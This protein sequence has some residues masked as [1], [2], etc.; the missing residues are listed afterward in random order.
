METHKVYA[1]Y[2][3]D[4]QTP[5]YIGRTKFSPEVRLLHHLTKTQR[6]PGPRSSASYRE[7]YEAMSDCRLGK[8]TVLIK[9]LM[10]SPSLRIISKMEKAAIKEHQPRFN[11]V[12]KNDSAMEGQREYTMVRFNKPE[13]KAVLEELAE[14]DWGGNLNL[15]MNIVLEEHLKAMGA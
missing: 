10:C 8:R 14:R 11:T 6:I 2:M 3:D 15:L 1:I 5:C 13:T 4:E 7:K 9:E 12:G